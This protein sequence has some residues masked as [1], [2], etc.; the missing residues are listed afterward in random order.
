MA[1]FTT[2]L[3]GLRGGVYGVLLWS[4]ELQGFIIH[5]MMPTTTRVADIWGYYIHCQPLAN[6]V[7]SSNGPCYLR[8]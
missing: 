3:V 5:E 7:P 4:G 6:G 8:I 1:L 2:A